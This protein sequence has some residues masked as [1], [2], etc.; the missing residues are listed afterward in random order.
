LFVGAAILFASG[1]YLEA[2]WRCP[3]L[4]IA[5]GLFIPLVLVP[6]LITRARIVAICLMA[7]LFVAAGMLRIGLVSESRLP[8]IIDEERRIYEGLVIES[9]PATKIIELIK[10]EEQAGMKAILRTDKTLVINDKVRVFGQMRETSLTFNNPSL[11]SWKWIKRLEGVW[12]EIKGIPVSTTAGMNYVHRWRSFLARRIDASGARYGGILKALTIGDT[13]GLDE[14]TKTLFLETG[15]SHILAISGSNIGIVTAFFFFLAR[16]LFRRSARVRLRGDDIRFAALLSIPF[17]ILFMITAGSSIPT[18]RAT[19]MICFFMIALF[20][21]RGAHVMNALGLSALLILLLYPHSLFSPSFQ[22]TFASVIFIILCTGRFSALFRNMNK[23]GRWLLSSVLMTIA[24]T[25]GTLPIVLYHFHGVNPLSLLHNFIAIPPICLVAMPMSL[26]GLVVPWGDYLLRLSGDILAVTVY[27]LE[28][29]NTGY[30]YPLM[31]PSLFECFLYFALVLSL[32]YI[33]IRT[34]AAGLILA[35]LPLSVCYGIYAYG[36]RFTHNSLCI[37]FIDVGLGDAMLVE[38]PG[39]V[40]MLIDG[41]PEVRGVYD[42]GKSV[43]TPVLLSRKIGTLDYVI[44]TH[45]HG[46]HVGGLMYVIRHF[47]VKRFA[48][49]AYFPREPRFLELLAL[50]REKNIPIEIWKKGEKQFPSTGMSVETLNPPTGDSTEEPNN[51]SLVLKLTY[52][53]RSF[54]LTGDIDGEIEGRLIRTGTSLRS[55]VLKVPHHGSRFGSTPA[56]VAAVKPDVAVLSVGKGNKGL[57]GDDAL[58][59]YRALSI[60][61]LRTDRQGFISICTDG[62]ELTCGSYLPL[63]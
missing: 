15:T 36:N 23:A 32:L 57:P 22:L 53:S 48:T 49:G 8:I 44:N 33:K 46:D 2:L 5:A 62:R 60:P 55:A 56:F 40:R 10:P 16:I 19:I 20:F 18:V 59:V 14:A 54:L 35:L 38:A 3:P 9:S 63:R 30:I 28:R 17:T 51:A 52:G 26:V 24:A 39:G 12:Y 34:V 4:W 43:I 1:I 27:V 61:L 31:R 11:S 50:L 42:V 13:S 37:D 29:L 58:R 7:F 21:E 25:I 45:P 6:F 47:K 41:G